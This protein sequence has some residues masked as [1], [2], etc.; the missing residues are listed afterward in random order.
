MQTAAR[1]NAEE[2]ERFGIAVFDQEG[3]FR[4]LA[5][6][7]AD[8]EEALVG[9][10]HEQQGATLAAL[11]FTDRS[12]AATRSLL[13]S[14][15]AIRGYE[16]GLRNAA[17]TTDEV[18]N[19]Q[20]EGLTGAWNELTSAVSDVVLEIGTRLEPAL[21]GLASLLNDRLL[22]A[23]R[24]IMDVFNDLPKP[25]QAAIGI[26]AGLAAALGPGL[27]VFGTV[28]SSIASITTAAGVLGPVLGTLG[29]ALATAAV[30]PVAALVLAI[31][32]TAGLVFWITRAHDA[33]REF[34]EELPKV[35]AELRAAAA[36]GDFE[37]F[38]KLATESEHLTDTLDQWVRQVPRA[39]AGV[40]GMSQAEIDA[41]RETQALAA[42]FLRMQAEADAAGET[43]VDLR[44]HLK[45][46]DK[47]A[48]K[49]GGGVGELSDGVKTLVDRLRG[50][51]TIQAAHD[52]AAA[53]DQVGGLTTLTDDET[54]Q[55]VTTLDTAITKWRALGEAVPSDVFARFMEASDRVRLHPPEQMFAQ[56]GFEIA[57]LHPTAIREAH[58]QRMQAFRDML[59]DARLTVGNLPPIGIPL[60][61]EITPRFRTKIESAFTGFGA[62]IGQTFARALEGGGGFLGAIQSLGVQAG[63][64]LGTFLSEGLGKR[65]TEG[66]GF[67][68]NGLGKVLGQAAGMAIP[69]IGPVIGS[70]IG[71][72]FSIGGPSEAELAGRKTAGAFRD[73]VIATLTDGQLAEASQAALGGA[74][75]GNEQGA[76]FL[77]GVRDAYL[78]VGKSAAT[79]ES[80]VTRLW[81]AEQRGP[82][83]VA[84]VPR[85]AV[86]GIWRSTSPIRPTRMLAKGSPTPCSMTKRRRGPR[87]K[88]YACWR[89]RATR[90]SRRRSSGS[91][92]TG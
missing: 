18:A 66:T 74:W 25:I 79:A 13:G 72:L 80:A 71:K 4:S 46:V 70:L 2:F 37:T 22:P 32:G 38:Q 44:A 43:T 68:A 14:S 52:W 7:V 65:M 92:A 78:A 40:E 8:V 23:V 82:E 34:E 67:L 73:G 11:G 76:Q 51:G 31:G 3:R 39:I 28:A 86:A 81:Q 63:N 15:E 45:E 10:S 57:D 91:R 55:L 6:I 20:L 19:K 16:E 69:L 48:A 60:E 33:M 9:M 50:T 87:L 35:E 30:G 56:L 64:R 5:D 24:T 53:L 29:T 88:R 26:L 41:E 21:L 85:R 17:G 36:A 89:T 54:R 77:I 61:P 1:N 90:C 49:T 75:R 42:A 27:F 59:D 47:M 84:A 83:A 58:A 12:I 62:E